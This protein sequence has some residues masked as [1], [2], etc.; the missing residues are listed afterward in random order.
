MFAPLVTHVYDGQKLD[1]RIQLQGSPPAKGTEVIFNA[2]IQPEA[3]AS[4]NDY[5][6]SKQS[7]PNDFFTKFVYYIGCPSRDG[8]NKA[9]LEPLTNTSD[10]RVSITI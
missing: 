2:I 7:S 8:V 5:D 1:M 9:V 4:A 10:N 3:F 6:T